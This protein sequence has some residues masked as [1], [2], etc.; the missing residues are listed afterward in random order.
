MEPGWASDALSFFTGGVFRLRVGVD[1]SVRDK[2]S[3]V[4]LIF[5]L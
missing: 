4:S 5:K 2:L 1:S 3:I